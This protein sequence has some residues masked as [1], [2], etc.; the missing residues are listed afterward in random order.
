MKHINF[1]KKQNAK[2]KNDLRTEKFPD[3][4]IVYVVDYTD[5]NDDVSL[6]ENEG[7]YRIGKASNIK[8]RKKIY[9]THSLHKKNMIIKF[10]TNYPIELEY[11]VRSMLYDYRYKNNKDFYICDLSKIKKIIKK[12]STINVSQ[13]ILKRICA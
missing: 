13:T 6:K 7:I 10:S 12:T 9:D 3:G 4:G 11:C 1:L 2:M 8:N 5:D